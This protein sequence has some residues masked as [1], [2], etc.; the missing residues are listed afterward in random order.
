MLDRAL[1]AL[2][3]GEAR[4]SSAQSLGKLRELLRRGRELAHRR[5][6]S[7]RRGGGIVGT[8]RGSCRDTGDL[9]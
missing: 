6:L 4:H 2:Q 7:L 5:C 1:I 9:L 3:H 8:F